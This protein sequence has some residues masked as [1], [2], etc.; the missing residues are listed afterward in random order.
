MRICAGWSASSGPFAS[1]GSLFSVFQ[2]SEISFSWG[3]SNGE[4][5]AQNRHS[6]LQSWAPN[7]PLP[8]KT[9][10]FFH[11]AHR[12]TS[13]P[14]ETESVH[15]GTVVSQIPRVHKYSHHEN[16][17][18][19]RRTSRHREHGTPRHEHQE[20]HRGGFFEQH[21]DGRPHRAA[22]RHSATHVTDT[23]L[24]PRHSSQT[25]TTHLPTQSGPPPYPQ[26]C[27]GAH[28]RFLQNPN[29]GPGAHF[30]FFCTCRKWWKTQC[31]HEGAMLE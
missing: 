22:Q 10:K 17:P 20:D 8:R 23:H 18:L 16:G 3:S 15:H 14:R 24:T 29:M 19:R 25:Q 4:G 12:H 21:R 27:P 5:G 9:A 13:L 1:W 31:K 2:A 26:R 30:V 11:I 6:H 7:T 28:F